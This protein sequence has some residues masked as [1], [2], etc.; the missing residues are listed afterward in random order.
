MAL[1]YFYV[2]LHTL[3]VIAVDSFLAA[4]HCVKKEIIHITVFYGCRYGLPPYHSF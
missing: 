2:H 4:F 1:A 3:K